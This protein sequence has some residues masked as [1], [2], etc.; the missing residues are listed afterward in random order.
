MGLIAR[1]SVGNRSQNKQCL[2]FLTHRH[3]SCWRNFVRSVSPSTARGLD[4]SGYAQPFRHS[5]LYRCK[6]SIEPRCGRNRTFFMACGKI[7]PSVS[8]PVV[9]LHVQAR[10]AQAQNPSDPCS[11]I[12]LDIKKKGTHPAFTA[13]FNGIDKLFFHSSSSFRSCVRL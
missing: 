8:S 10:G 6:S 12:P 11:H 1:Y 4:M 3:E 2:L 9:A 5:V 7:L 13:S